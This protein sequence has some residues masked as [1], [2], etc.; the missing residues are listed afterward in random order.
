MKELLES[1]NTKLFLFICISCLALFGQAIHYDFFFLD[2]KF[3][4]VD[5]LH[6]ALNIENL[7]WIWTHSKTP[8]PYNL[9]QVLGFIGGIEN[10]VFFRV[11][12]LAIHS[13]NSFIVFKI[14]NSIFSLTDKNKDH[15]NS[16]LIGS[17]LFLLHPLQVES[18]VWIS[19]LRGLLS[20]FFALSAIYLSLNSTTEGIS[21][22]T[23]GILFLFTLSLLSKPSAISLPLL[24]IVFDY[25]I[26]RYSS[27]V[28]FKRNI[29]Y[30][31][32]SLAA[33][34]LFSTDVVIKVLG[35]DILG[36]LLLVMNNFIT[37]VVN[38]VLPF[39]LRVSG[40]GI[41]L[42]GSD[43]IN[44]GRVSI[45][46]IFM[47]LMGLG[48]YFERKKGS[49]KLAIGFLLFLILFLPISGV[50][51]F[52]YQLI[53]T[54]AD[55]YM[56]LPIV[57]L[58]III[59]EVFNFLARNMVEYKRKWFIVICLIGIFV[60]SFNQVG[61]WKSEEIVI[62]KNNQDSFFYQMMLAVIFKNKGML[63]KAKEH[64]IKARV[65]N[66]TYLDTNIGLMNVYKSLNDIESGEKLAQ[67]L[68]DQL[69]EDEALYSSYLM[70]LTYN[71]KSSKA[72]SL[73]KSYYESN[74]YNPSYM[75]QYAMALR[76][77]LNRKE[78]L[79]N[80]ITNVYKLKVDVTFRDDLKKEIKKI[81]EEL[82]EVNQVLSN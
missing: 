19:S 7:K 15:F 66:P 38:F 18:V 59:V 39:D 4:I 63:I 27:K 72:I 32:I 47:S 26:H 46:F 51:N 80:Y 17:L 52:H 9:W 14:I 44:I 34:N 20:G 71:N 61:K 42:R 68:G 65:I 41:D 10:P 43:A 62:N 76:L 33:I 48:L 79:L 31:V 24:F 64:Y 2:D 36:N 78:D 70:I 67:R 49:N 30:W 29:L 5:N 74:P 56:Y 55:R 11:T 21:K 22:R 60:I 54:V 6:I 58:I 81:K 13:L 3:H 75:R 82:V 25:F 16:A 23:L 8:I 35:I 50:V 69:F 37:Y 77:S 40:R 12:N 73:I 1:R 57:G 28:I 45:G 53:S